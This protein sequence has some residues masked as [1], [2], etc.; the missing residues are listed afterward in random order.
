MHVFLKDIILKW[1][2]T[3]HIRYQRDGWRAEKEVQELEFEADKESICLDNGP[4][5]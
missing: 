4:R 5:R 2:Y 1:V 3:K